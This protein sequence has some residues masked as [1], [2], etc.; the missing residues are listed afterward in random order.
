MPV[1]LQLALRNYSHLLPK[2]AAT[3][4]YTDAIAL[5]PLS[6]F[7][8][9]FHTMYRRSHSFDDHQSIYQTHWAITLLVSLTPLSESKKIRCEIFLLFLFLAF[10][11][12][13]CSRCAEG[14]WRESIQSGIYRCFCH[15]L[16][17]RRP[18]G[19]GESAEWCTDK[20]WRKV[21]KKL[22]LSSIQW[23]LKPCG[24]EVA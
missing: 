9:I 5:S 2:C 22:H 11:S 4:H 14:Y 20:D 18:Q 13:L 16:W 15:C 8:R 21:Q 6:L 7:S 24:W 12:D 23:R 17:R 19:G 10:V 1:S 3:K